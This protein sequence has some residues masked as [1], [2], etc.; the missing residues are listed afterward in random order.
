VTNDHR[1]PLEVPPLVVAGRPAGWRQP[2]PLGWRLLLVLGI[3][4]IYL[5]LSG[6][7]PGQFRFDAAHYWELSLKF[8]QG[9]HL[10]LLQFDEPL[11]GY[12]GPLLILPGRLLCYLTGWP[13]LSGARVLGAVWAALLFGLAI[14]AAWK[15]A[16]GRA[17]AGGRWLLL[18]ALSFICWRDYFNFTLS[19]VPA[20]TLLL[21][22]LVALGRPGWGWAVLAG[23]LLAGALNLRP[24][25]AASVPA[26]LWLLAQ[27]RPQ[28][29][30]AAAL[31]LGLAL[32]L[33]PQLLINQRH[34]QRAT[35]LVL[36]APAT[37]RPLFLQQ[38]IWGTFIQRAETSLVP[39][40]PRQLLFADRVGQAALAAEP[41]GTFASYRGFLRHTL[42]HP[43]TFAR[44]CLRHAFNGLDIRF[45]TPY[46]RQLHPPG[47]AMLRLLN[48]VV[49]GFG[50]GL[51]VAAVKRRTWG[52]PA[53]G[54]VLLALLLPCLPV[55]PI[56]MECRFLLP[57]HLLVL[58]AVA[59]A[60]RPRAWWQ[61][62]RP[63]TRLLAL[64][65]LLAWVGGCW[66][67]S[68]DTARQLLSAAETA[69]YQ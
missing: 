23:L 59:A 34:F 43:L 9:G 2:W 11:R 58:T 5:P 52:S 30:R 38:L 64:V 7:A 31:A 25:Y 32:V 8:T 49:L 20:L 21:L 55:L 29:P 44:R 18:L 28:L 46:P 39:G 14:P 51:A 61:A 54:A 66:V 68:D 35:P 24:I 42:R 69:R 62:A 6:Y 65:A 22:G 67:L 27:Y 45:P 57:L 13:M 10:S 60:A 40:H 37:G 1:K 50:L 3:Y 56:S 19:D 17:L 15:L 63:A 26:W 12:L 33:A 41:G 36:G 48:Y 53:A 4:G 16:A 47:Q